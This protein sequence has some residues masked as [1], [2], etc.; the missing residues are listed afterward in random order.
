[1]RFSMARSNTVVIQIFIFSVFD[2]KVHI[3]AINTTYFNLW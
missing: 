1:M 3:P 2:F